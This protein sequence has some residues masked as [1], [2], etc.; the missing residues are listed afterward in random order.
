MA[1]KRNA[2]SASRLVTCQLSACLCFQRHFTKYG[3]VSCSENSFC[4]KIFPTGSSTHAGRAESR[5][6]VAMFFVSEICRTELVEY[7]IEAHVKAVF[8]CL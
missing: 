8:C 2:T 6:A 1:V 3:G 7:E 5:T 4:R